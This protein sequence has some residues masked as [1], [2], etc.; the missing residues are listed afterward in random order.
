MD[1][2]E[3]QRAFYN[4]ESIGGDK[5]TS[6]E[7]NFYTSLIDRL[8]KLPSEAGWYE[9]KMN[10]EKPELIGQ[11]I[12]SLS[13]SATLE[14]KEK[15]FLIWGISDDI[16]EIK[17]TSFRPSKTKIGNEELENWLVTQTK[18]RLNIIGRSFSLMGR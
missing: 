5:V 13:N 8:R 17:G 15:G 11:Y 9:Y 7:Q 4:A 2:V 12:S 16:H 1:S 6:L 3:Q 18:P 10:N 14:G